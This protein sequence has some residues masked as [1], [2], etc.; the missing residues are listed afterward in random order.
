L[1]QVQKIQSGIEIAALHKSKRHFALA[2]LS[3]CNAIVNRSTNIML[4]TVLHLAIGVVGEIP[5]D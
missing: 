5:N 4:G 2:A 1:N 3:L